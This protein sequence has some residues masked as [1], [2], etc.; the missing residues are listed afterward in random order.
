MGMKEDEKRLI[1][2]VNKDGLKRYVRHYRPFKYF[3]KCLNGFDVEI[4]GKLFK[5]TKAVTMVVLTNGN[6][7]S[8]AIKEMN[9]MT[10]FDI[11]KYIEEYGDEIESYGVSVCSVED[12]F[13]KIRGRLIATGRAYKD[14]GL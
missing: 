2:K 13:N 11:D 10:I 12:S 8:E 1:D 3:N 5:N 14:R 7:S 6:A 9:H 4:K